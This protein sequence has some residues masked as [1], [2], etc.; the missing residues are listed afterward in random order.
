MDTN[1]EAVIVAS[2]NS[3]NEAQLFKALLESAGVETRMQND[4]TAQVL[5][6]YG[7]MMQVNLLV[8]PDDEARAKEI[9]E[10]G[11]DEKKFEQEAEEES[12]YPEP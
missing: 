10:A 11:F 4:I 5:P 1:N 9:L 12:A 8:S 6:A 7:G 2:Y 3:V